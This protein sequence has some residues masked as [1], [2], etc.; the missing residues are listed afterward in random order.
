MGAME[1]LAQPEGVI[2][3]GIAG[4]VVAVLFGL[5][6][7]RRFVPPK[8]IPLARKDWMRFEQR[9]WTNPGASLRLLLVFGIFVVTVGGAVATPW[10]LGV[11]ESPRWYLNEWW[12]ATFFGAVALSAVSGYWIYRRAEH[13]CPTC[14]SPIRE[15]IMGKREWI[16]FCP[17]CEIVWRTGISTREHTS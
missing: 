5:A 2:S 3:I 16:Y 11:A 10:W 17:K 6:L 12:I 8:P 9:R 4:G 15:K 13:A 7:W 1:L 14:R